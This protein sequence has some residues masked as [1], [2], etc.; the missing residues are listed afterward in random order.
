VARLQAMMAQMERHS[1]QL[2]ERLQANQAQFHQHAE[3]AYT[4]LAASVDQTL[5]QSL[6]DSARVAAATLQPAVQATLAGIT[7]ETATL[8]QAVAQTVQQHLDGVS[9][10]L[11]AAVDQVAATW[12]QALDQ[13]Q[14]GSQALIADVRATLDRLGG[15]FDQRSVALLEAVA[16]SQ[17]R[18][19]LHAHRGRGPA[20]RGRG[21][22]P[23]AP[24]AV[25]QPGARQRAAGRTQRLM[26]TLGTLLDAV[27]PRI[28]R[29]A[30]RHRRAGGLV[31]R[32]AAAPG[33]AVCR[34]GG[35]RPHASAEAAAQVAGSALEVASLGEAFGAAVQLFSAVQRGSWWRSCSASR[36]R[37]ASSLAR[38]DEQLA[39]YV[40]QAREIIDLSLLSQKQVVDDLQR[41]PAARPAA[42]VAWW[43]MARRWAS[44]PTTSWARRAGVGG[45]RR[46]DGRP[47]G[48]LRA[49]PGGWCSACSW[50]WPAA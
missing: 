44:P 43:T 6:A 10:R 45:L 40:A 16:Q 38:S 15:G 19:R 17:A 50:T 9:G 2:N 27:Q 28:H 31:G 30:Q 41:W 46:P 13:Q 20:R 34:A 36:P 49:D 18:C 3:Q 12:S 1:L 5:R 47:A 22:R 4:A 29:T 25:Q 14:R 33:R 32:A 42:P 21:H 48:R 24:A 35:R 26:Q 11:D 8:H 39:Y 37:W 7:R 23:A